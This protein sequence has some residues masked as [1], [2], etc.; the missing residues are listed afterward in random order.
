MNDLMWAH[1]YVLATERDG[2]RYLLIN[3]ISNPQ[4][5]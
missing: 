3:C 2:V 1:I 4:N 5:N